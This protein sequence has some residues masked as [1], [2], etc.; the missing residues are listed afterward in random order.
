MEAARCYTPKKMPACA[1]PMS[2]N[3][4]LRLMS[5]VVWKF[6]PRSMQ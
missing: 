3:V 4:S 6:I 2:R 5:E 1:Q